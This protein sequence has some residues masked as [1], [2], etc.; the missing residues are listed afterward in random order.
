MRALRDALLLVV[1]VGTAA[2]TIP[3]CPVGAF[4]PPVVEIRLGQSQSRTTLP[5]EEMLNTTKSNNLKRELESLHKEVNKI[6]NGVIDRDKAK[7]GVSS[8]GSTST[9]SNIGAAI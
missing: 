7:E 3:P 1:V 4:R 5:P 8:E 9:S 6:L 2:A